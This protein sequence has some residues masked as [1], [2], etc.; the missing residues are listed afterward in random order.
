[1]SEEETDAF[2]KVQLRNYVRKYMISLYKKSCLINEEL[3]GKINEA[4]G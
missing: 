1:M 4:I 2:K 3:H